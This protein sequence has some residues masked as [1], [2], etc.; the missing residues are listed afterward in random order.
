MGWKD[1]NRLK[2][3]KSV[4]WRRLDLSDLG[5]RLE[6]LKTPTEKRDGRDIKE[7]VIYRTYVVRVTATPTGFPV[8]TVLSK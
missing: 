5:I 2:V 4:E 1:M 7:S 3:S 8:W 6:T